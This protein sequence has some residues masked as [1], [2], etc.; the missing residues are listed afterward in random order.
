MAHPLQSIT[1][2]TIAFFFTN[3]QS[4]LLHVVIDFY[5]S[6]WFT[7]MITILNHNTYHVSLIV[8]F[9]TIDTCHRTC[10]V[11]VDHSL[12]T[13]VTSMMFG[14]LTFCGHS[15]DLCKVC[16]NY[17]CYGY[18]QPTLSCP[19]TNL[20]VNSCYLQYTQYLDIALLSSVKNGFTKSQ[21]YM[22]VFLVNINKA[23]WQNCDLV[24]DDWFFYWYM[25]F[26]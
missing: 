23:T 15:H 5:I 13:P 19:I 1:V 22:H 12:W 24:P 14:R 7:H 20:N 18:K 11:W 21:Y 8:H 16:V 25:G 4:L 9:A 10:D 2:I 6:K 3:T 17:Y 26:W